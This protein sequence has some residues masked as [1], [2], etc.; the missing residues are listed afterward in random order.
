M[1]HFPLSFP[2]A[3]LLALAVS[4]GLAACAPARTTLPA[5]NRTRSAP[6]PPDRDS[7]ERDARRT[8]GAAATVRICAAGD[9]SLGT[10]LDTTWASRTSRHL[11]RPVSLLVAADSL[12]APVRPLVADAD[13][14]IV[15]IEG[16]IGEGTPES[17]KCGP[18]STRCFAFRAPI[19]A[20]AAI[21]GIAPRR[22]VVGNLANNHA[23]DAGPS[24]LLTTTTHLAA[25]GVHV[26]GVDTMPTVVATAGGD[27]L[28]ILGFSTSSGPDARDTAAVHRHVA[29]A[30][31]LYDR[32]V[33]TM[34]LGAEG[35][36]AQRTRDSTELFLGAIDRGNP[37][38]FAAAAVGG[39]AAFIVGHGPHVVRAGEW[40][41]PS[42]ALY[43]LGNLV[44][45]GPFGFGEPLNR[46]G[47]AC[48]RVN[49]RGEVTH[50]ELRPTRQDPPGF[51]RVD[52]Q[53]RALALADSLSALDFPTTGA[54]VLPD[55]RIVRRNESSVAEPRR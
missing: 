29:R 55:G 53:R 34:H 6:P 37:V 43:S 13:V 45:Y 52:R 32:V 11:H 49:R 48:V 50:A 16:A 23:L 42:L 12:V 18:L 21:R 47:V 7:L 33:V 36:D 10:N 51:V 14:V 3:R 41:G 39:G 2:R 22:I 40:R 25:A 35:I 28:A 15:N 8:R 46:G 38:A 44:T 54:R 4:V 26:V 1:R 9:L 27:T 24:G 19:S 30:V 31:A 5:P 17:V 20:A